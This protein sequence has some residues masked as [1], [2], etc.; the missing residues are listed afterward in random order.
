[1]RPAGVC[2][3]ACGQGSCIRGGAFSGWHRVRFYPKPGSGGRP[4]V[5]SISRH[6]PSR[7]DIFST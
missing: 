4:T 2:E 3:E 7:R 1:V 5:T 6:E